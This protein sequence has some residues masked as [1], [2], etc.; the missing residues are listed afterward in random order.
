MNVESKNKGSGLIILVLSAVV[1]FGL[2]VFTVSSA[3]DQEF[4][5]IL[6]LVFGLLFAVAGI[7]CLGAIW[8]LSNYT[9]KGDTLTVKTIFNITKRILK[10]GDITSYTEIEKESKYIKWKDLTLFANICRLKISSSSISNYDQLKS[11]LTKDKTRDIAS[12]KMWAYKNNRKFGFGFMIV[13]LGLTLLFLNVYMNRDVE[14]MVADITSIQAHIE[15]GPEIEH[16]KSK[17]W[18][19]I[20]LIEYPEFVFK[21]GGNKLS[22]SNS[23]A[24]INDITAGDEIDIDLLTDTYEKKIVRS[25]EMSYLDRSV[26]FNRITVY[27]LRKGDNNY[28]TLDAINKQHNKDSSGW[29]IWILLAVCLGILGYGVYSIIQPKPKT[30]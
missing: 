30:S 27:G 3:F 22:A 2:S 7:I 23:A 6:G 20:S 8:N 24:I 18:I 26:N 10:L 14:V 25:K 5:Q 28:L 17:K 19:D 1:S 21:I 9:I 12:E 13:G 16:R 15:N 4:T 11:V 29:A